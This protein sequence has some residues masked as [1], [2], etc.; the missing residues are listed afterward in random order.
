MRYP[1]QTPENMIMQYCKNAVMQR[2]SS[3]VKANTGERATGLRVRKKL[4]TREALR[5]AAITL[6]RQK[7][8]DN[9]TVEDICAAAGV[10][11]RTFFNYFATKDEA[12][13]ALDVEPAEIQQRI[14]DRPDHEQ[15][16]QAIRA[17][18]ADVIAELVENETWQERTLL[19]RERP[20]LF[21]RPAQ[22]GRASERAIC[23]AIS[24][25][26][27]HPVDDLY[28]RTAAAAVHGAVKAAVSCWR[29]DQELDIVAAFHK[30]I[31]ML[32][33]GLRPS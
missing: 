4:A 3:C 15:P 17:V 10:S 7:G 20:E 26:T 5:R 12:V 18:Y 14:I 31:D 2:Y 13:F 23:A 30:A 33:R 8:P 29:P 28:V 21:A 6:Y 11:P 1:S 27:G 32:A 19:F 9:V 22:V 24:A 16:L 25:R